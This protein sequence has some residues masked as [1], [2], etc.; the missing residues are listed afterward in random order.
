LAL[1]QARFYKNKKPNWE[2]SVRANRLRGKSAAHMIL[3]MCIA[4]TA[5]NPASAQKN[6]GTLRLYHNDNPPSA[7]L[8]EDST[9]AS[10]TPFAAVFNNLVVFDP[11]KVHESLDTVIPDLAESWYQADLQA[12]RGREM[13]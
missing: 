5:V 4:L 13:A 6:G 12:A 2:A 3:L 1:A 10:V 7:S 9:I 8:L 11:F